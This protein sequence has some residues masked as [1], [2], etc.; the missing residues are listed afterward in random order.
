MYWVPERDHPLW[1][2]GCA[3]LGRDPESDDAGQPPEYATT[4]WRYGFH[5]TLVAPLRLADGATAQALH[6]RLQSVV[7]ICCPFTLPPLAVQP[8]GDFLALRPTTVLDVA[9]P[10]RR[11]ADA[12]VV[13][14]YDLQRPADAA[15]LARRSRSL[16]DTDAEAVSHLQR[17][18]YPFVFDRWRLHLTL[19]DSGRA[20]DAVLR[21][22]AETH[23]AKAL[24]APLQ[25]ASVAVFTQPSPD[26]PLRLTA[27]IGTMV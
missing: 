17:W 19:S 14:C 2:A 1:H 3:W 4:P 26:T 22:R 10:M 20:D 25:V 12:C 15:E 13:A 5:A 18:G 23:F 16:A 11:L 7:A 6:H 27:R 24:A 21:R 8:L 9:H